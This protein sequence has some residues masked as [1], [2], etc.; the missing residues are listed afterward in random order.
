MLSL[1]PTE[2]FRGLSMRGYTKI[3]SNHPPQTYSGLCSV[4]DMKQYKGVS[5]RV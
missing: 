2:Q 1:V 3:L 5:F 4:V